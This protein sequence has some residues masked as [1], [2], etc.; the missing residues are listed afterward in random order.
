LGVGA[1]VETLIPTFE[2][3]SLF[4]PIVSLVTLHSCFVSVELDDKP[5]NILF[6]VRELITCEVSI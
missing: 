6:F 4:S 2:R 3:R 5:G 1:L